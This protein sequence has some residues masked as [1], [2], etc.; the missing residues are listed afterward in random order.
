MSK[1]LEKSRAYRRT[2]ELI[3]SNEMIVCH[4]VI[5]VDVVEPLGLNSNWSVKLRLGGGLFI[6]GKIKFFTTNLSSVRD[7]TGVI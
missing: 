5:R 7:R 2:Y 6:A 1:A 4:I 3:A